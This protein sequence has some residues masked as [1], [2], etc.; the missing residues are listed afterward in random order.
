MKTELFLAL[1]YLKP[2]RS[3]VSLIAVLAVLGVTLGVMV[4]IVVLAVMSGFIQMFKTKLLETQ[5]HVQVFHRRSYI[6]DPAPVLKAMEES[7]ISGSGIIMMPGLV[8]EG[9][10]SFNQKMV[11]GIDPDAMHRFYDLD[12]IRRDGNFNLEPGEILI[13][14]TIAQELRAGIGDKLLLHAPNKL[15]S[16]IDVDESG[17]VRL[18]EN[19]EVFL[20]HEFTIAGTFSFGKYDFDSQFLF[21]SADD[22]TDLY[23][24][25]LGAATMVYGWVKD[26]FHMS[27]EVAELRRLL[28]KEDAANFYDPLLIRTWEETNR[29]ML[30]VL[31]VE[32]NTMFF[33]LLFIILVAAFSITNTLI[34]T[35]YQKTR[36]I[37]VLKA[38]GATDFQIMRIFVWQGF[39][40]GVLGAGCGV[41]AGSTLIYY[42][43]DVLR[44][45]RSSGHDLFPPQ[46]YFFNELP[47]QLA[48]TDLI[49][50]AICAI[51]LC[52][53]GALL[54]AWR[55]S[56]LDP[57]KALRYE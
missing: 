36:E 32:K 35:V 54:P 2:K 28:Q 1:R 20:P 37:G 48:A 56:R 27:A 47:A 8:Q 53:V 46:F 45:L 43:N 7:G 44:L 29:T 25:P 19:G 30:G 22:A 55:A 52:T 17:K 21:I 23:G 11:I 15:A 31:Q 40:V 38:L 9:R 41:A 50:V 57:A 13:S 49:T 33:L 26:P 6:A 39:I 5:S 42:R 24:F 14:E 3:E 12:A 51:L 16:L 4:L 34:T 10:K 18:S